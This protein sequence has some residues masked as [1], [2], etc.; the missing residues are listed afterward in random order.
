MLSFDFLLFTAFY[1]GNGNCIR[2]MRK[3]GKLW[4]EKDLW[5]GVCMI[6]AVVS[7]PFRVDPVQRE[8]NNGVNISSQSGF[9]PGRIDFAAG[10]IFYIIRK[11]NL[12]IGSGCAWRAEVDGNRIGN[13]HLPQH[14]GFRY[15]SFLLA[16]IEISACMGL[17]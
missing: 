8:R 13:N 1:A 17:R 14:V 7:P 11:R 16:L 12:D 2:K 6:R 10:Y 4:R 9:R 15:R 5:K 3:T